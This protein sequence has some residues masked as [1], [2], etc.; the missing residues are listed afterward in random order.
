[1][2]IV[3]GVDD[4]GVGVVYGGGCGVGDEEGDVFVFAIGIRPVESCLSC[5]SSSCS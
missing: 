4:N 3:E 2:V 5:I 1:M